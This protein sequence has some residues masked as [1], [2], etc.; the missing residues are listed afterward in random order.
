[1]TRSSSL[2]VELDHVAIA[3]NARPTGRIWSVRLRRGKRSVT[4]AEELGRPSAD[5]LV[6]QI[7]QLIGAPAA[8]KGGAIE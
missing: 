3:Q 1:M 6:A 2:V 4:I 8:T 7:N 5:H